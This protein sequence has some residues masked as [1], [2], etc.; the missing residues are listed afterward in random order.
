MFTIRTGTTDLIH[1]ASIKSSCFIGQHIPKKAISE[2]CAKK[3][4]LDLLH[5]P[6]FPQCRLKRS[7][8]FWPAMLED[9][10]PQKPSF[11]YAD[12]ASLRVMV[13]ICTHPVWLAFSRITM[14]ALI[15]V[16]DM[17]PIFFE[18]QDPR[19][20]NKKE[21]LYYH[22]SAWDKNTHLLRGTWDS[23][24]H[25]L[26]L[27]VRKHPYSTENDLCK[28]PNEPP[29]SSS[30]SPNRDLP[31]VKKFTPEISYWG[32]KFFRCFLHL[33]KRDFQMKKGPRISGLL[34]LM[35]RAFDEWQSTFECRYIG[36]SLILYSVYHI[37]Y[38]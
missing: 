32:I 25:F 11:L 4:Q 18:H 1:V 3:P 22:Y 9:K 15:C 35:Y 27:L 5:E 31:L 6:S 38:Q 20:N 13:R 34:W 8:G 33:L 10:M 14:I 16:N 29:E 17:F 12:G 19:V 36:I 30:F 26:F 28:L 23:K 2:P 7:H 21:F 24:H 37:V